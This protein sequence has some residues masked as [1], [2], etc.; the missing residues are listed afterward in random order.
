MTKEVGPGTSGTCTLSSLRPPAS[1]SSSKAAAQ[2][3]RRESGSV[4]AIG[5]VRKR[6]LGWNHTQLPGGFGERRDRRSAA[7]LPSSSRGRSRRADPVTGAVASKS[8]RLRTLDT[9]PGSGPAGSLATRGMRLPPGV[10]WVRVCRATS[11]VSWPRFYARHAIH[12]ARAQ[13][14][15]AAAAHGRADNAVLP[16]SLPMEKPDAIPRQ[17]PHLGRRSIPT[18]LHSKSQGLTVWPPNHMSLTQRAHQRL[19]LATSTAPASCRRFTTTASCVGTRL[20]YGS[21]P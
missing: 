6:H 10:S 19:S 14:R 17:S 9:S 16:V 5:P 1:V 12:I 15:Y 13:T 8:R 20:R 7:G 3:R 11:R 2:L 18:P 21:A 4:N